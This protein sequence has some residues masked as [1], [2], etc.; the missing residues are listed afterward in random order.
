MTNFNTDIYHIFLSITS[1]KKAQILTII[2]LFILSSGI[3]YSF[4]VFNVAPDILIT[5]SVIL[6]TF[7]CIFLSI[8]VSRNDTEDK[9]LLHNTLIFIP[10]LNVFAVA[11]VLF[12]ISVIFLFN[13]TRT[14]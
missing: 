8:N 11:I 3:L 5:L 1:T 13:G 12:L 7:Y 2:L 14:A 4:S 9:V 10:I 6:N